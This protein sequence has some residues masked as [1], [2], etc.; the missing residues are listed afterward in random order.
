MK[1]FSVV[2]ADDHAMFRQ[3]IRRILEE[4]PGV[5]VL[6]ESGDGLELLSVYD[7]RS[8]VIDG[9]PVD[10]EIAEDA[11]LA[12]EP[13]ARLHPAQPDC[14]P[15]AQAGTWSARRTPRRQAAFRSCC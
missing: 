10:D 4:L 14:C 15:G 5:K 11:G 13:A 3:G 9:G 1:A 8:V 7:A 6:G 2:L 12:G